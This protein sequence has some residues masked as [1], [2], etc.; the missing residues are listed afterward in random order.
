MAAAVSKVPKIVKREP[1]E[2]QAAKE[3][4]F[5]K[6]SI[7]ASFADVQKDLPSRAIRT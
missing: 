4:G 2:L 3:V 6:I 7:N 5:L 1:N